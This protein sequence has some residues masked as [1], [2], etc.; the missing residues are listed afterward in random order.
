MS[1][2]PKATC[3]GQVRLFQSKSSGVRLVSAMTRAKPER[4]IQ[5]GKMRTIA[6]KIGDRK[7]DI[8]I[9]AKRREA[10]DL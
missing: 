2:H 6:A 3:D 1:V 7:D 10:R 9:Y 5:A 4:A 8:A